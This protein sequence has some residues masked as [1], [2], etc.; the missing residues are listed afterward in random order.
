MKKAFTLVELMAVIVIISLIAILTFPN[1][2]GQIKKTEKNNNDN[3]ESIVINAAKKYVND[4][5]N[6]FKEEEYNDYCIVIKD[7]V[8]NGYLKEDIVNNEENALINKV[9]WVKYKEGVNYSLNDKCYDYTNLDYIESTGT[10]YIDTNYYPKQDTSIEF[11]AEAIDITSYQ[12]WFGARSSADSLSYSFWQLQSE[13]RFD[14]N[15]IKFSRKNTTSGNKY[16]IYQNK[17]L[18]YI[19]SKLINEFNYSEFEIPVTLF[20]FTINTSGGPDGRNAKIK[21]YSCKI[22]DNEVLVRYYIPVLDKDGIPCLYDKVEDKYYYNQG[23][24]EFLYEEI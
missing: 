10:Q 1:I 24:G 22:W 5:P 14:Y 13:F 7:L 17:N 8:D 3:I 18:F 11:I 2:V 4:N 9:V 15:S 23:K 21:L 6:N 12:A 16:K 20:L 19:D